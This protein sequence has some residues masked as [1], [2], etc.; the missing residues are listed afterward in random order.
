MNNFNH[1]SNINSALIPFTAFRNKYALLED[2][3]LKILIYTVTTTMTCS[4]QDFEFNKARSKIGAN[5]GPQK[6]S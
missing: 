6:C 4:V 3:N 1:N 2:F 5:A